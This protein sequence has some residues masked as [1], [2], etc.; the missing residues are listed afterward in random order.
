MYQKSKE[1]ECHDCM[2]RPSM[3]HIINTQVP[4]LLIC[5]NIIII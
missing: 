3:I 2:V 4:T 1:T 5:L